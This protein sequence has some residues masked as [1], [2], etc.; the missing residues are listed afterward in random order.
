MNRGQEIEQRFIAKGYG[1]LEIANRKSQMP[2]KQE[3][4]RPQ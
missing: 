4:L 1:E 3:A 2:G